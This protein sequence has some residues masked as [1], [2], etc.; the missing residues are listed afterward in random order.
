M[1]ERLGAVKSVLDPIILF[2]RF[3]QSAYGSA[4]KPPAGLFFLAND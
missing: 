1:N 3:Y 2:C 4:G